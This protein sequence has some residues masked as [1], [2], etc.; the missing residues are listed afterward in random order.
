MRG[1][2]T[3]I[4]VT[5]SSVIVF[6]LVA[7][8]MLEPLAEIVIQNPAVQDSVIDEQGFVDGLLSSVLMWGPMIVLASGVIS[9]VVYYLR[10]ER[11]A[12]RRRP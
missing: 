4:A 11:T 8:A 10:R 1:I 3:V 12:A 5:F 2:A 9:A 6:T 7:P